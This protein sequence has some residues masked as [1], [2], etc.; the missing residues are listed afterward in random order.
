MAGP[1]LLFW[2][3]SNSYELIYGWRRRLEKIP[4]S[5]PSAER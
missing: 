3:N 1:F 4:K 5:E 2:L